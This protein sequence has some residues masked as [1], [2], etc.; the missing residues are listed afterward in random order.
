[1]DMAIIYLLVGEYDR[2]IEL[3]DYLLSIPGNFNINTFKIDPMFDPLRNHP[4]Y[5]P[6]FKNIL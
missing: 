2:S 6:L 1:M 5:K 4:A 3:I